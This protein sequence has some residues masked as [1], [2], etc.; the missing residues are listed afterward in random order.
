MNV[1]VVCTT[2]DPTDDLAPMRGCAMTSF[3]I[4]VVPAFR[5]D[6]ARGVENPARFNAW[7]DR[8]PLRRSASGTR[9]LSPGPR[10]SSRRIFTRR[11]PGLRS[12]LEEPYAEDYTET[13]CADLPRARAGRHP[14][15]DEARAFK[16]AVL[17]GLARMD[18]EWAGLQLHMGAV[19]DVNSRFL[20]RLGP[21]TGV[22]VIGDFPSRG[23]SRATWTRWKRRALPK[24]IL[25]SLN[26]GDNAML[27]VSPAAFRRGCA[28]E[29]QSGAAWWFNDQKEGME[30][31]LRALMTMGLLSNFVG[32]LTDSRSFLSFPRHEYFRRILCAML[33]DRDG[34]GELPRD[35]EL[36]GGTVKDVCWNNAVEYFA[37][38]LKGSPPGNP[39]AS[40]RGSPA[41]MTPRGRVITAL[42]RAWPFVCDSRI[43]YGDGSPERM[44]S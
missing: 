6:P 5:P 8:S 41:G 44:E 38:P 9:R 31:H 42:A 20:R 17:V 10:R 36:L 32:M 1:R 23:R 16:T 7:V 24:T 28:G 19:R 3:P 25:Y 43:L 22:D 13:G 21:K 35:Y 11:L 4:T 34:S 39:P 15:E 26:P 40:R 37:F 14:N 29:M 33:G 30:E 27:A 18:A 2:D 12:R